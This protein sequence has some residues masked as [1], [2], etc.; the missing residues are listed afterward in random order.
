MTVC[1]ILGCE[2][3]SQ[4]NAYKLYS[5]PR[6]EVFYKKWLLVCGRSDM[7]VDNCKNPRICGKHFSAVQYK[8][9]FRFELCGIKRGKNYRDLKEDAIP[10]QHLPATLL[11]D[12]KQFG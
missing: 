10:D 11:N 7:G 1:S 8:R 5:F 9:D 2:T 4:N 6:C 12:S 3:S